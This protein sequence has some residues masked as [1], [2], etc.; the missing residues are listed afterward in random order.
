[1]KAHQHASEEELLQRA[2][3][4]AAQGAR[5]NPAA[6]D[7]ALDCP[8]C[9]RQMREQLAVVERLRAALLEGPAVSGDALARAGERAGRAVLSR[10][11][12][13]RPR[14]R[15]A[16]RERS[17]VLRLA[18][19]SLLVHLL[20]L[21]VLAFLAWRESAL[22]GSF[23]LRVE[24]RLEPYLPA[25]GP[26][27]ASELSFEDPSDRDW[28]SSL[29]ESAAEPPSHAPRAWSV[30][31]AGQ[32]DLRARRGG[33]W[34]R[35][36]A[37]P[38]LREKPARPDAAAG[39][40][41]G[42]GPES[43]LE[44]RLL[45]RAEVWRLARHVPLQAALASA[46]RALSGWLVERSSPAGEAL[47]GWEGLLLTLELELAMDALEL[48][49]CAQI[50]TATAGEQARSLAQ[51]LA[52]WV[53]GARLPEAERALAAFAMARANELG[54]LTPELAAGF[55][56]QWLPYPSRGEAAWSPAWA[57]ALREVAH[58]RALE[59][60]HGIAAWLE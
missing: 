42:T 13:P 59:N 2:L 20:A 7:A 37:A 44:R 23:S 22:R 15:P 21:P 1:V 11:E 60:S 57:R 39:A 6:S 19:A 58:S 33:N 35:S 45:L 34:I 38:A 12:V 29:V 32:A 5:A 56:A 26:R 10:L 4:L 53:A 16:W 17:L 43:A 50:S 51:E 47:A 24:E 54:V 36:Q 46:E 31:E 30:P 40:T 49:A 41:V 8:W 52:P 27:P 25:E 14:G 9:E 28:E 3:R 48:S 55:K 18:A